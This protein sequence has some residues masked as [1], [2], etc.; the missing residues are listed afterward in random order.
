ML[1][2][3]H[4]HLIRLEPSVLGGTHLLTLQ[5]A[6][7]VES[8]C[9]LLSAKGFRFRPEIL[10]SDVTVVIYNLFAFSRVHETRPT[11]AAGN[12]QSDAVRQGLIHSRNR[13]V[14]FECAKM[15]G[16]QTK[17]VTY[18]SPSDSMHEG[19]IRAPTHRFVNQES[20]SFFIPLHVLLFIRRSSFPSFTT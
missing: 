15:R 19:P 18:K 5:C 16:I 10:Y 6:T 3:S 9:Q 20:I 14:S 13:T 2:H 11:T 8:R 1:C 17:I 4:V 12:V 7:R